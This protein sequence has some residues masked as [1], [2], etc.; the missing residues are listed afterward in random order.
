MLANLLHFLTRRRAAEDY[1]QAFVKGVEV[2]RPRGP[3]SRRSERVLVV[4]WILIGV[5][6][7]ASWWLIRRY[8]MPVDPW[9]I[10]APTLMAAGV[11]TWLYLRRP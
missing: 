10:V 6:C 3:R 8:G 1:D 9:W 11:C 2:R 7:W 4:G 5:K